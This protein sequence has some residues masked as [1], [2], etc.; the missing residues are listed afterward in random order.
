M[1]HLKVGTKAIVQYH[2]IYANGHTVT[3]KNI[4]GG[5]YYVA[6]PKLFG[7]LT[8]QCYRCELEELE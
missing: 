7:G 5:Y 1:A 4:D 8:F 2:S 3:I 6:S